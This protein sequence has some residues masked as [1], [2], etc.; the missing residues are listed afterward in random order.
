MQTVEK[1]KPCFPL[2][3][4]DNYKDSIANK[5]EMFEETHAKDKIDETFAWTTS[6]EYQELNFKREALT[7]N[8]PCWSM[9]KAP[10]TQPEAPEEAKA[11]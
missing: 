5:R 7:I 9:L 2:F 6:M 1:I 8:N 11:A 3:R 10:W 4:D